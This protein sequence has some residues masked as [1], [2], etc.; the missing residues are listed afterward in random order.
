MTMS[1]GQSKQL[2]LSGAKKV[3]WKSS[4]KSV[5][6]VSRKGKVT[7]KKKGSAVITAKANGKSYKCNVTINQPTKKNNDILIV[8]FFPDRNNKIGGK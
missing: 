3:T 1:K 4:K 5:A 6:T 8:Y 7:A 2:K